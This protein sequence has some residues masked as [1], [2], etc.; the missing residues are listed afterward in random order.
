[1]K[2]GDDIAKLLTEIRDIQ[3]EQLKL[4]KSLVDRETNESGLYKKV[5]AIV[6][7]LIAVAIA[8]LIYAVSQMSNMPTP[9]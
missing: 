2:D 6:F 9:G 3:R 8:A 7:V 5:V 1:M 4:Q